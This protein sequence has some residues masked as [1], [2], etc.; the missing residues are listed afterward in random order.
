MTP[1]VVI[2]LIERRTKEFDRCIV[3]TIKR[4]C[5]KEFFLW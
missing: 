5:A 3:T 4:K 2:A 1:L